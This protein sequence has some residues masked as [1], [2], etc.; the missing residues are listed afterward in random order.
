MILE[1]Q[2]GQSE[3]KNDVMIYI[4]AMGE[5]GMLKSQAL[6]LQM[7]KAGI[8]AECDTVERSVKAQMKY[9]NKIN[10][11]YTVIIGD[12]EIEQNNVE[13]KQMQQGTVE[14][15]ALSDLLQVMQQRI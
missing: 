14:N 1:K 5:K 9:A 3:Q 4:G 13:L 11:M 6:T 7:R 12:T 2:Y 10:A 8:H 15:V